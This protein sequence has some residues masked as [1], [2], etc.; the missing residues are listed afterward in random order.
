[1]EHEGTLLLSAGQ[2]ELRT[3]GTLII[4]NQ[5]LNQTDPFT[6]NLTPKHDVLTASNRRPI[7]FLMMF[8][9]SVT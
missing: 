3:F 8:G 7:F 5:D 2:F 4:L 9:I 6:C 1:M